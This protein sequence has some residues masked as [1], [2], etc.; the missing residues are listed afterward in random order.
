MY[1]ACLNFHNFLV[2]SILYKFVAL[3]DFL[4]MSNRDKKLANYESGS[5]LGSFEE[6][7]FLLDMAVLKE[8]DCG[9]KMWMKS[10]D[11]EDYV[12]DI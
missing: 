5:S 7:G 4:M 2:T 1:N 11:G 10:K 12:I 8:R 9:F 6:L 3:Y